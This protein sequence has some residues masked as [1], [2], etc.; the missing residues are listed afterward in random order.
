MVKVTNGF[1]M[2]VDQLLSGTLEDDNGK[3]VQF[4]K[5]SA[6]SYTGKGSDGRLYSFSMAGMM[7]SVMVS[8]VE[9]KKEMRKR[10]IPLPKA[11]AQKLDKEIEEDEK[12]AREAREK[13][14]LQAATPAPT[15]AITTRLDTES[16]RIGKA[17]S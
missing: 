5:D 17:K 14:G 2:S 13:A 16:P 1:R 6:S 15:P 11:E 4:E 9:D 3:P 10:G 7:T 12:R 8:P